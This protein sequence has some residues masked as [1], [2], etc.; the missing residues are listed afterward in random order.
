MFGFDVCAHFL[1]A[2]LRFDQSPVC[3]GIVIRRQRPKG[4]KCCRNTLSTRNRSA[5]LAGL[6]RLSHKQPKG[7]QRVKR[8]NVLALGDQRRQR[9]YLA[10]LRTPN[11]GVGAGTR[12]MGLT[13]TRKFG[14][15]LVVELQ[16]P[17][18]RMGRVGVIVV[19]EGAQYAALT[20]EVVTIGKWGVVRRRK[21]GQGRIN[22]RFFG[23]IRRFSVVECVY[24]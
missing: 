6:D 17:E 5:G 13:H 4:S 23:A 11:Q 2:G 24:G 12:F 1:N 19:E 18:E 10:R 20:V 14:L 22:R 8:H 16:A 15:A 21:C 7:L 9:L 3:I